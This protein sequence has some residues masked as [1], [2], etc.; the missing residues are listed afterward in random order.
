MRIALISEYYYPHFGGV[1]EHVHYLAGELRVR[2]HVVD[3]VTSHIGDAPEEPGLIRLGRSMPVYIN[4]SQARI[5]LGV[6]RGA[7]R[8]LFRE[9]AYDLIHVHAPL[10]PTL[11]IFAVEAAEVPVVGTFHTNFGRSLLYS[12]LHFRVARVAQRLNA[13]IAVSPTAATAMDRYFPLDWRIVPNG[14]DLRFFR[15]GVPA[16]VS[17]R[18]AIPYILFLGRLDPRNGLTELIEAFGHVS[19]RVPDARLIV[20]GDGPLRA[21]YQ[22]LAAG[23]PAIHFEGAV[24]EGRPAYYANATV[25]ACPTTKA[26]F[27]ITLLEAMA[28]GA[29]I[30][31]SDIPGF[32]DVVRDGHD[33][34]MVPASNARALA[35]GLLRVLGDRALRLR[36]ATAALAEVQRYDWPRVTDAITA[37]Y[38][39]AMGGARAP[40]REAR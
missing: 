13:A 32:T 33:C 31:C 10:T 17:M 28:C 16:P 4:G 38:E 39:E 25:Y 2:G 21:H 35:D 15:P 1:T 24:K 22:R 27:G 30:V 34:L 19:E 6:G 37:V 40:A 18:D 23:N 26:S 7:L 20:V 5:T 36:L 11:P 3:I 8:R 29:P 9:R 14:V 12:L